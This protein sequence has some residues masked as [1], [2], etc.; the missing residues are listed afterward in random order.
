MADNEVNALINRDGTISN[1]VYYQTD[2][3]ILISD[4]ELS[5]ES[6]I[7]VY[8]AI[9]QDGG[10]IN[11]NDINR[12]PFIVAV[13]KTISLQYLNKYALIKK[14]TNVL[15]TTPI[16]VEDIVYPAF[17]IVHKM[18]IDLVYTIDTIDKN[19]IKL[20]IQNL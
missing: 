20:Q 15:Y 10:V 11:V 4:F 19:L 17:A 7:V 12:R 8:N 16:K 14:H 3:T 6:V 1:I 5:D 2:K 13:G 18:H 9:Q